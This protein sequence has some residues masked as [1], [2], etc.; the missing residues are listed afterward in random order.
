MRVSIG[1]LC[2]KKPFHRFAMIE[3]V[4]SGAHY[5]SNRFFTHV[6]HLECIFQKLLILRKLE[7]AVAN[8]C[9]VP[10]SLLGLLAKIKV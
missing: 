9:H 10:A 2:S 5:D 6:G 4:D 3:D 8:S 1:K 7:T